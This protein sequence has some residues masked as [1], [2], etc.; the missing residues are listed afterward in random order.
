[1]PRSSTRPITSR[2]V[3]PV[4][5]KFCDV[6]ACWKAS[7]PWIQAADS[8]PARAKRSIAYAAVTLIFAPRTTVSSRNTATPGCGRKSTIL[9]L[10]SACA[11]LHGKAIR[12]ETHGAATTLLSELLCVRNDVLARQV[13]LF[14]RTLSGGRVGNKIRRFHFE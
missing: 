11:R 12:L 4:F 3:F 13:R 14:D 9:Q 8:L 7:G 2:A 5:T 1:M 6:R 10:G